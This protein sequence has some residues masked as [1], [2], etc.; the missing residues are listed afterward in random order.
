GD[1]QHQTTG[2]EPGGLERVRHVGD[3]R[4]LAQLRTRYVD[5]ERQR[6]RTRYLVLPALDLRTRLFEHPPPEC[7]RQSHLIGDWQERRRRNVTSRRVTP[8]QQRFDAGDAA[9][10]QND[11]RLIFDV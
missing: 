7:G 9:A 2:V 5:R 6:S 10:V 1:I 11:D 4:R 3:E 8:A